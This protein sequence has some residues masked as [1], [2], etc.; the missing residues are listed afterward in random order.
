M[1]LRVGRSIPS[2]SAMFIWFFRFSPALL[3]SATEAQPGSWLKAPERCRNDR[4]WRK[5]TSKLKRTQE[6]LIAYRYQGGVAGTVGLMMARIMGVT[7]ACALR[8]AAKLG[9]AMQ[10]TNI[11]RDV[12]DWSTGLYHRNCGPRFQELLPSMKVIFD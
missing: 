11:C 4:F 7:D 10:L 12:V 1:N 8:R 9:I 2:G 3:P 6:H 5:R